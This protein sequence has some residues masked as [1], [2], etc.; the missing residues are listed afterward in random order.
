MGA[1]RPPDGAAESAAP[2]RRGGVLPSAVEV[3]DVEPRELR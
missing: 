2:S 1:A 3:T